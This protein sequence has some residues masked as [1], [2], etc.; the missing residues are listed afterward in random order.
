MIREF[1]KA[2]FSSNSEVSSR[3]VN[4][5]IFI[6]F[7]IAISCIG[8]FTLW[9]K[10]MTV[11]NVVIDAVLWIIVAGLFG[12]SATD[13]LNR[14]KQP[15][16]APQPEPQPEIEPIEPEPV[17]PTPKAT[18]DL[19]FI[20]KHEGCK[21]QAYKCPA[22]VWTIGY[23]STR[24]PNG[25]PV[26]KG[27]SIT[28]DQAEQYLLHEASTRMAQMGLPDWMNANQR[29]A[30][31]SWQYN[32]GQ[33][34]WMKSNLRKMILAKANEADIRRQWV[35]KYITANGK[36]LPGLIRRRKEEADLYFS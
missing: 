10:N 30:C 12:V 18:I 22:G 4:I 29:T 2:Y 17:Q 1:L 23:G 9:V 31:L 7:F 25:M 24:H 35:T 15:Q 32:C 36:P 26:K 6:L 14:R 8:M 34:A 20:K 3:R 28:A 21:L 5:L 33:G 16:P 19:S 13:V 27:D 11:F